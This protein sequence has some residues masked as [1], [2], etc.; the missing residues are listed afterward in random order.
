MAEGSFNTHTH[1]FLTSSPSATDPPPPQLNPLRPVLEDEQVRLQCS[2]PVPCP[3]LPP[4]IS[5]LPQDDFT[6]QQTHLQQVRLTWREAS[7]ENTPPFICGFLSD[8]P[9]GRWTV[10]LDVHADLHRQGQPSQPQ[11]HVLRLL[12]PAERHHLGPV[13]RHP[14]PRRPV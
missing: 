7:S 14:G 6:Q 12:P 5:W 13:D 11:H 1:S 2:V 4:S 8:H 10:D 3:E 9:E